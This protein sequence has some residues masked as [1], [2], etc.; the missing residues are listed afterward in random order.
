LRRWRVPFQATFEE[1]NVSENPEHGATTIHASKGGGAGKWLLGAVAAVVVAGGAYAA[2]KTFSPSQNE[3]SEIAYNDEQYGEDDPLRAG[4]LESDDGLTADSASTNDSVASPAPDEPRA[5]PRRR[6]A[7]AR[8]A[9]AAEETIGIT[10]VNATTE[11]DDESESVVVTGSRR[12]VWSRTPNARYL[13]A[14]YPER[15]RMRG[16]EGEASLHCTVI[17]NGALDCV[18][19]E[20]T[21][22]TFGAAAMRVAGAL[23]HAPQRADGSEAAG[24]PVNLRVVFRL[25]DEQRRG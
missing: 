20:E 25:E 16:R 24:T 21:S 6:T 19:V 5:T 23:R 18:R 13:T 3:N 9:E 10:P 22:S 11:Y 15:A 4:P 12:P 8:P 2:W 14:L 7:A 17:E 1:A